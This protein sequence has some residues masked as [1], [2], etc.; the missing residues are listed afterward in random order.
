MELSSTSSDVIVVKERSHGIFVDMTTKL[1]F[2]A[3]WSV[4]RCGPG[5]KALSPVALLYLRRP[6]KSR[7]I[8]DAMRGTFSGRHR[9]SAEG[10]A[11][12]G[13]V[14]L[15]WAPQN[16]ITMKKTALAGPRAAPRRAALS[17]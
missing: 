3:V 12:R 9:G 6:V 10:R 2:F 4:A 17:A 13:A 7:P 1:L 16:E 8:R 5:G 15:G 14:G 11:G